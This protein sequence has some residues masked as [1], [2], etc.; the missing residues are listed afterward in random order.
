VKRVQATLPLFATGAITEV[1]PLEL[2]PYQDRCIRLLRMHT[3]LGKK[4]I[5]C[6]APTRSGKAV[7]MAAIAASST[8]PVLALAHRLELIDQLVRQLQRAGLQNL[9]V[10]RGDDERE[11]PS[12]AIQVASIQ[13]LSRR[14]KP[15]KGQQIIIFIDEAHR[16]IADSYAEILA[17][18][19]DAIVIGFTATPCR[20]DGR[21][22]GDTYEVLEVATT[23]HELLKNPKW[24]STPD[25]YGFPVGDLSQ[26]RIKG[27]DYDEGELAAIMTKLNGNVVEHWLRLAPLHPVFRDGKRLALKFEERDRRRT[28][29][30]ACNID[31]SL[32][33]CQRF[34]AAGVRIAHVDAKT[35]ENE[36]RA[37]LR[38]LAVGDLEIVSNVNIFL[39]GVD[40]PEVKCV[41]HARPTQS[42]TLWR[43]S[44]CR[45]LTP[46]NDVVP[47]IL[48]HAGN[49]D[50]L[51]PPHEDLNWSL[52]GKPMRK[53]GQVP[54][55]LCKQC[56]A[57][58]NIFQVLCPHCGYEFPPAERKLMGE[59][60]EQLR[61]R[62]TEPDAMKM[63]FFSKL[64]TMAKVKAFKPGFAA[65][66]YKERYGDW[67]PEAWTNK[68]KAEYAQ[69][70]DWQT[71]Q[72]HRELR[73]NEE[74][75]ETKRD[76]AKPEIIRKE[77]PEALSPKSGWGGIPVPSN[78]PVALPKSGWASIP[79]PIVP[80]APIDA[81]DRAEQDIGTGFSDWLDEQG[82]DRVVDTEGNEIPDDEVPF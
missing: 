55:K 73:K 2:R 57:Y 66:M 23:Y 3:Q 41:S 49:W 74:R 30:F 71:R 5:L 61:A 24:L 81:V 22:M 26:V 46:W 7:I 79:V 20:L 29:L 63:E 37:A 39:E 77:K 8:L 10:I 14:E 36:R 60:S 51:W 78:A 38:S 64:A 56:F 72:L 32:S 65:A 28:F 68:V 53:S 44:T 69:D 45:C 16:S 59:T 70:Q 21:G 15:F 27:G 42:I 47:L 9:G 48:D 50:R 6:V 11:N 33:L 31:H 13:T 58:V 34:E 17:E 1:Q 76:P 54:M 18:Y 52:T 25:A 4:R 62:N 43:Q 67:P 19:P 12:A 82:I 35:P 75:K 40:V 80:G